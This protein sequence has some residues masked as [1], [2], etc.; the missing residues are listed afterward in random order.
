MTCA[1]LLPTRQSRVRLRWL[2][3]DCAVL[4]L[5]VDVEL[6]PEPWP[7]ASLTASATRLA[8]SHPTESGNSSSSGSYPYFAAAAMPLQWFSTLNLGYSANLRHLFSMRSSKSALL[9]ALLCVFDSSAMLAAASTE[10]NRYTVTTFFT[11][12]A[13]ACLKRSSGVLMSRWPRKCHGLTW[14][15]HA[16]TPNSEASAT[17]ARILAFVGPVCGS[18]RSGAWTNRTKLSFWCLHARSSSPYWLLA[19]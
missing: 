4:I 12:T 16:S 3:P 17:H 14:A 7:T 15:N 11:P 18:V 1:A 5:H 8:A 10:L 2:M 9:L 19:A 13:R 6:P